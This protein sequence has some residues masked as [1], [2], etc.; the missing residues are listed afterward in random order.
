M[1]SNVP[2]L[3]IDIYDPSSLL[4][5][6]DNYRIMRET[7]PIIRL[8]RY[9]LYVMSR[10]ADVQ[11]ALKDAR[12]F[13]SASGVG[14]NDV[15]NPTLEPTTLGSDDPVHARR[16]ALLGRPLNPANLAKIRARIFEEAETFV[17]SLLENRRFDAAGDFAQHLPLT[18]VYDLL[19]LPEVSREEMMRWSAAGFNAMGPIDKPL[20]QNA[21][22]VALEASRYSARCTADAVKPGGWAD[23]L[24]QAANAGEMALDE[25]RP[26]I[27]DYLGPSLDTT[28][29][30][31]TNMM[32]LFAQW[33]DQ[34]QALRLNPAKIPNAINE[35]V[36]LESPIQ[37]FSRVVTE[38]IR[39]GDQVLPKG[40]RVLMLYGSANRDERRWDDP[41]R[42]DIDRK[43][44]DHVGFGHGVHSCAGANLARLEISALLTALLPRVERI[45]ILEHQ[46]MLNNLLRGYEKLELQVEPARSRI[47]A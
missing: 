4:D 10:F 5:P 45:E 29:L 42:F 3:D 18:I 24:Y 41:T 6:Y 39:I 46:L 28:M 38:A 1:R 37:G 2:D 20:T 34:W 12:I 13:S 47:A 17:G 11:A 30:A 21:I 23:Q 35:V 31:T 36:R 8:P 43:N 9:D 16:R 32:A 19:G 14:L 40:A 27:F 15:I 22:E 26:L 44:A 25:A 33:P 7:A